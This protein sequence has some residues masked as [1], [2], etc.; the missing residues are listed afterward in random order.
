MELLSGLSVAPNVTAIEANIPTRREDD[1]EGCPQASTTVDLAAAEAAVAA[2]LQA[3]GVSLDAGHLRDTPSRMA[4]AFADLLTPPTFEATT[5]DNADYDELVVVGDIPFYSLCAHHGL[6]F[7]GTVD[8]GYRPGDR[9]VG[10][11]KLAWVVALYARRMQ[12]QEDLTTLVANWLVDNLSPKAV[13]VRVRAE[14]MCMSLRGVRAAGAVT[15]TR[16]FRG[17]LA[18]DPLMR[19]E[20]ATH[21]T[22]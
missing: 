13:G 11:S 19:A 15:E 17:D 2:L 5:F 18:G 12:V 7:H 3:L 1:G 8:V 14:H 22:R 16:A 9:I 4:R 6:P 20:W 10:L 21:F